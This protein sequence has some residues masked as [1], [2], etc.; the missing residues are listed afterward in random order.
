M[1]HR[2]QQDPQFTNREHLNTP[3]LIVDDFQDN[4]DLLVDILK[5]AGYTSLSHVSSGKAALQLLEKNPNF[6]LIL[7]DLMMPELDGCETCSRITT[8]PETRHIPVIMV[9]GGSLHRDEALLRSFDAGAVDFIGKPLQEVELY[10]RIRAALSLYHERINS[11]QKTRALQKSEERFQLAVSGVNDGIWDLNLLTGEAYLSP[12]WKQTLGFADDELEDSM[13][14]WERF[15]HPEDRERV[16]AALDSHWQDRTSIY[17]AEHRMQTRNGDEIWVLSRGKTIWDEFGRTVRMAGSMTD[18]TSQKSL[19]TQLRHI[20]KMETVGRF[21]GGVA[22][23]FNNI[24]ALI[25]AYSQVILEEQRLSPTIEKYSREIL[26]ATEQAST[27]TRQ[28]LSLSRRSDIDLKPINLNDLLSPM[29]EMLRR[30]VGK[31]IHYHQN[32]DSELRPILADKNMI[33]QLILNLAINAR[34]AMVSGTLTIET[35]ACEFTADECLS[36]EEAT[37]GPATGIRIADTG[38]GMDESTMAKIFEPFFTTKC[39]GKGTGLG[40]STAYTVVKQHKGWI[41]VKSKIDKGTTFTVY[42][43]A[44]NESVS[45]STTALDSPLTGGGETIL[46]VEDEN[47]LREMASTILTGYNYRVL[48]AASGP[49]AIKIWEEHN[50]EIALLFT[51]IVMPLGLS[52]IDIGEKFQDEKPSLKI[53]YTSGYRLD[54][55][56]KSMKIKNSGIFIPKPYIPSNLAKVIRETLDAPM[57]L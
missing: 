45:S 19:E 44:L 50:E 30:I 15:I 1:S 42:F 49:E 3:I 10:G 14:V 9:T 13:E 39:E 2:T 28:L 35:F 6:G 26:N 48:S 40:L 22:H 17:V 27:L 21:A 16:T 33:E 18:I 47:A 36:N 57:P 43:P 51:D 11:R 55:I 24:L 52:G 25:S 5:D 31:R 34:D 41:T 4:I 12:K 20:Q 46:L 54:A 8:R 37:E 23:D 38:S 53:I 56:P 7:L 29:G 32:L